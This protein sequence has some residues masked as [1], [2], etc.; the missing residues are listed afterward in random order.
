MNRYQNCLNIPNN[1]SDL[2]V[3]CDKNEKSNC[4]KNDNCGCDHKKPCP[5]VCDCPTTTVTVGRTITGAPGSNAQVNNSGT[6]TNVV[7]DFVVP[8]GPTGPQGAQGPQGVPGLTGAQGA[9]GPQGPQ[10]I[11][12]VVGATGPTGPTGPQGI[13]GAV[14]ATGPTGPTGATGPT[15]PQGIAGTAGATGPTGPTGATGPTGPQGISGTVGATGP[16]GPTGPQGIAGAVGA[17]GPTGPTGATGPT[18]PAGEDGAIEAFGG[19]YDTSVGVIT[20]SPNTPVTIP[21]DSPMPLLNVTVADNAV[22]VES[23]GI[24][25]INY[26]LSGT[27]ALGN[28][29]DLTLSVRNNGA[30]IPSTEITQRV[31]TNDSVEMT[32]SVIVELDAG[33]S[34]TLALETELTATFNLNTTTNATLSVKKLSD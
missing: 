1:V 10:G 33:D 21:L 17:T 32:G 3:F 14:G 24:Y 20:L 7:L 12:G 9:V 30:A 22:T 19:A 34:L 4:K 11:A 15:G 28:T 6:S 16:T 5:P 25:E 29:G 13:A 31:T 27:A 18:G 26:M 8:Q 23:A 2:G